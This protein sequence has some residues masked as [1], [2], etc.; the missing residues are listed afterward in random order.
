M[1]CLHLTE[2]DFYIVLNHVYT[3]ALYKFYMFL[4][5]IPTGTTQQ[6]TTEPTEPSTASIEPSTSTPLLSTDKPSTATPTTETPTPT[7]GCDMCPGRNDSRGH[8]W[9]SACAGEI[10]VKDTYC[11]FNTSGSILYPGFSISI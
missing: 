2:R 5:L 7:P 3:H 11:P 8:Y 9:E 10:M 6:P 4:L 1:D